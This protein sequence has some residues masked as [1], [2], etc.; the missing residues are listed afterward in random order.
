MENQINRPR[1]KVHRH[2]YDLLIAATSLNVT[3]GVVVVS[4][5]SATRIL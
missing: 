5:S 2:T 1:L 4:L 3:G